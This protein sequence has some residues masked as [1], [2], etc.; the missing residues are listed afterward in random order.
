M[1]REPIYSLETIK[2]EICGGQGYQRFGYRF[3]ERELLPRD[4]HLIKHDLLGPFMR[5]RMPGSTV[6]EIGCDKGLYS[7]MAFRYGAK[8]VTA[9]DVNAKLES[10]SRLLFKWLGYPIRF[11]YGNLFEDLSKTPY[12]VDYVIALAVL[13]QIKNCT[14]EEKISHIRSM[15]HEGS[16]IEFCED[17]QQMFG[18]AWNVNTFLEIVKGLYS[19]CDIIGEYDAIGG[20]SGRRYIC[21]C[22][23]H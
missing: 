11:H 21:D 22:R 13:H 7:Y 10:Y 6:L 19:T 5:S 8:Q 16:L 2:T 23:C 20:T 15:S 3:A 18:P 9:N 1:F 12:H 17:Y 14:L 4:K